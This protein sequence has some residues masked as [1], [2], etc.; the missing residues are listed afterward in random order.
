MTRFIMVNDRLVS[1]DHIVTVAECDNG[2]TKITLDNGEVLTAPSS[3]ELDQAIMGCPLCGGC[4]SLSWSG[5]PDARP[6]PRGVFCN[7]GGNGADRR[8]RHSA[9]WSTTGTRA[10][11][12]RNAL[13]RLY[14]QTGR[15]S[16]PRNITSA[17]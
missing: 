11:G 10:P 6:G 2:D 17:S 16:A 1:V 4:D 7:H 8:W 3:Q 9:P 13:H 14:T 15:I 5:C 12:N